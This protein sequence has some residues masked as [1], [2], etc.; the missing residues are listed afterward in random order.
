MFSFI[1]LDM[2]STKVPPILM[3]VPRHELILNRPH[4]PH[5]LDLASKANG[6]VSGGIEKV[7]LRDVCAD[8]EVHVLGG[9]VAVLLRLGCT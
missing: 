1:V 8:G 7:E 5:R 4:V 6:Q 9:E 3:P 2:R